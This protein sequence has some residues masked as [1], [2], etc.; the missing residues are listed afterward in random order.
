MDILEQF[1]A[2]LEIQLKHAR[3]LFNSSVIDIKEFDMAVSIIE[4]LQ[5]HIDTEKERRKNSFWYKFCQ[6]FKRKK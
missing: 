1:E 3:A 2:L 6:W 4:K 5:Y